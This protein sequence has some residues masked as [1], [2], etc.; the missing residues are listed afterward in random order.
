MALPPRQRVDPLNYQTPIVDPETGKPTLQFIQFWERLFGNESGTN[1]S[2]ADK[3]TEIIAGTGL[4]GGGDLSQDRTINLAD[5]AVTPG[6]YTNADITVDAQGRLTA[7]AN[8]TGGSGAAWTQVGTWD[9]TVNVPNVD[10]TGLGAYTD[11]RLY[12]I[13]LG[14]SV[15]GIRS[16]VVSVDNGAT[17]FNT[18]GEYTILLPDGTETGATVLG[19][20]DTNAT[21]GRSGE[22]LMFGAGLT[23]LQKLALTPHRTQTTRKFIASTA[24]INALRVIPTTTIGTGNLTSGSIRLLAR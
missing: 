13:N 8:G 14:S 24:P 12:F 19:G 20:H 18:F 11:F 23:T 7:A 1:A 2:K 10:F 16:V 22:V 17:W 21:L 3:S 5:T 6:S 4:D 9:W 15:S